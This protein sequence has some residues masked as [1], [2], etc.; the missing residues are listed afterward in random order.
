M[1]GTVFA[2]ALN[3]QSQIDAWH[4]AFQQAPYRTPP[5]TPVWFIKPRNTVIGPQQPIPFP[6]GEEVLSGGTLALVIGKTAHKVAANEADAYIAGYVLANEVSLP[7]TSFYRPA[8]KAK[9]RD[10]FCPLGDWAYPSNVDTLDIVTHINGQEVD[11]WSTGDLLRSAAQLL[12][13][14]SDFATLLPGDVILLGTPQ[15]RVAIKPGDRVTI[16]AD[17][18]PSL[19]NTVVLSGEQI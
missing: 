9:C 1:K 15:H 5:L 14:L 6:V 3:H 18:F 8:I 12:S 11:R 13:A 17:G 2:V 10:G 4:E 7:E 19:E 16:S